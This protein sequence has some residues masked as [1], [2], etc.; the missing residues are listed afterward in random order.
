MALH[1]DREEDLE[2]LLN[3]G[4]LW[5]ITY[6]D[7]MSY[8]MIFFLILFTFSMKGEKQAGKELANLQAQF[9]GK[10]SSEALDRMESRSKEVSAAE[11]MKNKLYGRGLQ[12]F[13]T[14]DVT[15]TR[16]QVTLQAP[17]LFDSGS[18]DFKEEG[19]FLVREF[20][21]SV[22]DL[23]NIIVVEGHTDDRPLSG[24]R[25]K[26]NWELSTARAASV[27]RW[28]VEKEGVEPRRLSAAGFAD[29]RPVASNDTPEGRA[30]NRRIEISLLRRE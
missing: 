12:Q 14:V 15:E 7:L 24:G 13:V 20:A 10:K 16:I 27:V 9:G 30:A 2:S 29:N 11:A 28:L 4:S 26:D 21:Q 25:Y 1:R 5:A 8:L 22:R 23:P 17:I 19:G 3:R 18:A 6:G